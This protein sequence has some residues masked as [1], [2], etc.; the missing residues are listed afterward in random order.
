METQEG[1]KGVRRANTWCTHINSAA[2]ARA[3]QRRGRRVQLGP[4]AWQVKHSVPLDPCVS[5]KRVVNS[6]E[7][8]KTIN[9]EQATGERVGE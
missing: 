4:G 9:K 8:A 5:G 2:K 1:S 7:T 3:T 6:R